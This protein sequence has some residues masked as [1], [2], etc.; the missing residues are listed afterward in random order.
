MVREIVKRC[1]AG[2]GSADYEGRSERLLWEG[3]GLEAWRSALRARLEIKRA[4]TAEGGVQLRRMFV[5]DESRRLTAGA[6]AGSPRGADAAEAER[7][8]EELRS[9]LPEAVLWL[10]CDRTSLAPRE[11]PERLARR[12]WISHF[13]YLVGVT[14]TA[15]FFFFPRCCLRDPEASFRPSFVA[16][17]PPSGVAAVFLPAPIAALAQS[18]TSGHLGL[19]HHLSTYPP[20]PLEARSF[21][22]NCRQMNLQHNFLPR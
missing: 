16:F 10:A 17:L 18:H 2:T 21:G 14:T 3:R 20:H 1:T 7:C 11:L 13:R 6:A 12:P 19:I 5:E 9:P 15:A 22:G 8:H 4:V